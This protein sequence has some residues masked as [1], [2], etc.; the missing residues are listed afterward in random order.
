MTAAGNDN[1]APTKQGIGEDMLAKLRAAEEEAAKL[2]EELAK[3]KADAAAKVIWGKNCGTPG[4]LNVQR[5]LVISIIPSSLT[6]TADLRQSSDPAYLW[7]QGGTVSSEQVQE[8]VEA[9]RSGRIDGGD[10]R[11]LSPFAGALLHARTGLGQA[12]GPTCDTICCMS[13]TQLTR[14]AHTGS[15]RDNWLAES[16]VSF[17]NRAGPSEAESSS[18][19]SDSEEEVV[20]VHALLPNM[21]QTLLGILEQSK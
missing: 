2:R 16:D 12:Q 14:G 18:G 4:P 15:G 19:V 1:G 20:K 7:G 17:L 21:P 6:S 8:I 5:K 11:R 13:T 3:A 9:V 10:M